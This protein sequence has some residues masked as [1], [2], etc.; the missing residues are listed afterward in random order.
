MSHEL[1]H[2]ATDA[3]PRRHRAVAG[4]GVRRLRR[5]ARHRP[6]GHHHP[7]T[8]DRGRAPRRAPG[9]S[10]DCRRLRHPRSR[11]PGPLRGGLARLPDRRRATGGAGPCGG[12][13]RRRSEP[14]GDRARRPRG[15]RCGE[16]VPLWRAASSSSC[17]SGA[18]SRVPE[19]TEGDR[20]AVAFRI[21]LVVLPM[22]PRPNPMPP[23]AARSE[24][25][26]LQSRNR[27]WKGAEPP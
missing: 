20:V 23:S 11:S 14:V 5:A 9:R 17:A 22:R 6:P 4:G 8:G 12:L 18:S 25:S 26:A 13:R 3:G 16:L 1:A 24:Q 2:V 7:R 27:L 15:C 19:I 21:V 10:A